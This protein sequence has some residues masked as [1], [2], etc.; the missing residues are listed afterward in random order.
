[1]ILPDIKVVSKDT[2]TCTHVFR[3]WDFE[4]YKLEK[5]PVGN[6]ARQMPMISSLIAHRYFLQPPEES[7]NESALKLILL[8]GQ[9]YEFLPAYYR[10]LAPGKRTTVTEKL[11]SLGNTSWVTMEEIRD[12]STNDLM[13]RCVIQRVNVDATTRR[14]E[15]LPDWLKE[16]YSYLTSSMPR[17]PTVQSFD[18][19]QNPEVFRY[20]EVV[21]PRATDSY[22][23]TNQSSYI[24]YGMDCATLG[25]RSNAYSVIRGDIDKY[26]LKML[27]VLYQKES[28][29][30]DVL[31]VESWED[32]NSP[33]TLRFQIKKGDE[34]ITQLT[35]QFYLPTV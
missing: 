15:P 13:A 3:P 6:I 22:H 16:R 8:R 7:K 31:D 23:H 35:M 9:K 21:A 27:E 17:P 11:C 28:L 5:V 24:W 30:G 26:D 10:H 18:V 4:N 32:Q 25:A 33:D 2:V 19:P 14:P 29:E 1:R 20:S 12:H 34:N